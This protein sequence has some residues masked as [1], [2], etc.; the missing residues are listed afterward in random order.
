MTGCIAL[1]GFVLYPYVY[2]TTR[3]MFLMQSANL[4]DVSR[5]L[6]TSRSGVFFRVALPLAPPRHRPR[7]HPRAARSAQRHRRVGI[8]G[9]PHAH[10]VD[11]LD[12]GDAV[13]PAWRRADSA[14][15]AGDGAAARGP[16]A[17]RT[18][19]AAVRQRCAASPSAR[20]SPPGGVEERG[21]ARDLPDSHWHRLRDSRCLSDRRVTPA[22]SF[23]R[24]LHGDRERDRQHDCD[25]ASGNGAHG[26]QPAW[27]WCTRCGSTA[28][29]CRPRCPASRRSATPC[30]APCWR[31]ACCRS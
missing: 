11:L 23:R 25:L 28:A 12:L 17:A 29:R 14:R 6:G 15:H 8:S 31:S 4:I 16:G 1:L 20:T 3:A 27:W 5:T 26:R 2:L 7:P 18:R 9:G 30:Q 13:G 24:H 21:G 19:A 22:Y 10:R